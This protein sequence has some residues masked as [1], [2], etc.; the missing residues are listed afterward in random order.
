MDDNDIHILYLSLISLYI[1]IYYSILII[2]EHIT[3]I[4]LNNL[5]LKYQAV[6]GWIKHYLD[7]GV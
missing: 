4:S 3:V 2:T 7:D 5:S 6:L 1:Y